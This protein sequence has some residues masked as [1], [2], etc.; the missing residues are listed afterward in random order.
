[1]F[2][3]FDLSAFVT[4]SRQDNEPELEM[5][6]RSVQS[7]AEFSPLFLDSLGFPFRLNI[8][9]LSFR[10]RDKSSHERGTQ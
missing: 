10:V 3:S 7:W 4:F 8:T 1:M 2:G 5:K 6:R 9:F